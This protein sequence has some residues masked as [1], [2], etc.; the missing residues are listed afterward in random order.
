MEHVQDQLEQ[1]LRNGSLADAYWALQDQANVAG[2]DFVRRITVGLTAIQ[3]T[4]HQLSEGDYAAAVATA[5]YSLPT[6][7][8]PL[9]K[10]L[11]TI[12]KHGAALDTQDLATMTT[13][14]NA[15]FGLQ[16]SIDYEKLLA[17][18]REQLFVAAYD[19]LLRVLQQSLDHG[20]IPTET[21]IRARTVL[22]KSSGEEAAFL[23]YEIDRMIAK[24]LDQLARQASDLGSD[25]KAIEQRLGSAEHTIRD[26]RTQIFLLQEQVSELLVRLA[27]QNVTPP[28]PE[29]RPAHPEPDR[30]NDS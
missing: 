25:V 23:S 26:T 21:V 11:Y 22:L 10:E 1:A 30:P 2:N 5:P 7:L 8:V 16:P 17:P 4:L 24:Q 9:A 19:D 12:S 3:A 20:G 27:D 14:A 15:V 18:A 13:A 28:P 29:S 6:E